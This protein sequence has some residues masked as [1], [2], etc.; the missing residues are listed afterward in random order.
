MIAVSRPIS[1]D[2]AIMVGFDGSDRKS[3]RLNSSH[4][5][6]SYAVFC[7]KKKNTSDTK[8]TCPLTSSLTVLNC[9]PLYTAIPARTPSTTLIACTL[10]T[11]GQPG[12]ISFPPD[13]VRG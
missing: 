1:R 13:S 10:P 6:I 3:T 9:N 8:I 4:G 7:L 11:G 2:T 12:E 5:Y